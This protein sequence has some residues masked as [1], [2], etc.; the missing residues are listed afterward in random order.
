M[1]GGNATAVPRIG[2]RSVCRRCDP[3]GTG[4]R[5]R[6][7]HDVLRQRHRQRRA[8]RPQP[9]DRLAH[10][11]AGQHPHPRRV[12]RSC[13]RA[14]R[15][16]RARSTSTA[17]TAASRWA[18]SDPAMPRVVGN[19]TSGDP[20]PTTPSGVTVRDLDLVGD[21]AAYASK[22]GLSLYSD[23]PAGQRLTGVSDQRRHRGR[24]SRTGWR[25]V[26]PTPAP[27]SPRSRSP[28]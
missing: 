19:G 20:R 10:A 16:S 3:C 18:R 15:R 27:A 22:G 11:A 7:R 14:A 28:A 23:L 24:A 17:R 2:D 21:A 5:R 13:S 26:A 8:R 12:T 9:C 6:D 1:C 4:T 25:S